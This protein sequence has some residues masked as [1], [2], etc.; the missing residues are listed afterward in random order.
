MMARHRKSNGA[1]GWE[2]HALVER[3]IF[4][5]MITPTTELP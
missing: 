4:I 1:S 2:L 5:L 3:Y